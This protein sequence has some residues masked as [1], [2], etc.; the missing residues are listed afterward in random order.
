MKGERRGAGA[1]GGAKRSMA[2]AGTGR[3]ASCILGDCDQHPCE[4]GWCEETITGYACHCS[5]GYTGIHCEQ[6]SNLNSNKPLPTTTATSSTST[7][8]TSTITTISTAAVIPTTTTSKTSPQIEVWNFSI[9]RKMRIMFLYFWGSRNITSMSIENGTV[10]PTT[11]RDVVINLIEESG[12]MMF[13]DE[14]GYLYATLRAFIVRI[15]IPS[16]GEVE[17][18]YENSEAIAI[19]RMRIDFTRNVRRIFFVDLRRKKTFYKDIDSSDTLSATELTEY[20]PYP[21]NRTVKDIGFL[22]GV[23]YLA[24]GTPSA[25]VSTMR[26][27]DQPNR[28]YQF[29]EMHHYS[30][31]R[32]EIAVIEG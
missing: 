3:Q 31:L 8:T 10:D 9:A 12:A 23:I 26:D 28:S 20:I 25:G 18:V 27:Y 19:K 24:H 30:P 17:V 32:L 16:S 7:I 14:Q 11:K 4:N 15:H 22:N 13:D 2:G 1:V 5:T 29:Q 6:D 21:Q